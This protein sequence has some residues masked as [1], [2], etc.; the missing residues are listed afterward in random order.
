MGYVN[1]KIEGFYIERF[2][3]ICKSKKILLW[4]MKREKNSILYANI[5]VND[6]KKIRKIAQKTKCKIK[7]KSKKGFNFFIYKYKNRKLFALLLILV[8]VILLVSLQFIWNIDVSGI[9][10][11]NKDELIKQLNDEG[12]KIGAYKNSIDKKKIINKIRLERDDI[13]WMEIEMKGTNVIVK[14]VE[15]DKKP[16]I[17]E[18]NEYCNIISDRDGIITKIN[19]QNGTAM[20]K[21]GDIIK[22]GDILVEGKIQGKYTEP[23][24]VHSSADIEAK[25][26]YSKR[27]KMSFIQEIEEETGNKEE[28]YQIKFNNFQINL[29]KILSKFE[30]YDTISEEENIGIFAKLNL[31]IKIVKITNIEKQKYKKTYGREELQDIAIKNIEEELH[32]ELP[33][34][35]NVINRYVNVKQQDEYLDIEII[36][37]VLES[38][39]TKEK[40]VL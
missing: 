38:I 27:K 24:Y 4:N 29:Y 7:L 35:I 40:L 10:T 39:G 5:S 8:L 18:Q 2:I 16:E 23:I 9:K 13:A 21:K 32:N 25:I 30:N 19:V 14:V 15:T 6:F 26:W 3:N 28:K 20:V 22:K 17:V 37:E 12:V 36:Y 34:N 1:I 11:I 33:R 31:P